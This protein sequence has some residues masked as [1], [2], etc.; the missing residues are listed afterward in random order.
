[1]TGAVLSKTEQLDRRVDVD[2][3]VVLAIAL[4]VS[5][6]VLLLPR[7]GVRAL[8]VE[9]ELAPGMAPVD[10]AA[11][12]AWATGEKPL[13][14]GDTSRDEAEFVTANRPHHFGGVRWRLGRGV[15]VAYSEAEHALSE[16]T[17]RAFANGLNSMEL[18]SIFEQAIVGALAAN[19]QPPVVAAIVTSDLGVLVGHRNDRTPPW[20][21]IAGEQEP[22]ERPEDTA[23]R[24]VKEETSLEIEVG[25][26]IG[27]R[28]HPATGRHMIYLAGQPVRGTKV[29]VGDEAEL[30]EVRWLDLDEANE[31]MPDMFGPVRTYLENTIAD[32]Q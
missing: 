19:P 21:F 3:L 9:G 31:V 23:V 11:A 8:P 10:A 26:V 20:T 24:E 25:R 7:L 13:P 12:W 6:N 4:G 5:P 22:G 27:E 30:D 28:D 14:N 1:M 2:D 18:R 29:I 15:A 17:R 32:D 16:A